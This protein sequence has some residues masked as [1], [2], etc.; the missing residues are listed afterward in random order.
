LDDADLITRLRRSIAE[1]DPVFVDNGDLLGIAVSGGPDSMALL[2]LAHGCFPGRIL[3]ATVDHQLR[4]ES[5]SEAAMVHQWCVSRGI[6]HETLCP[7]TPISGSVQLSARAIRYKLLDAWMDRENIRWLATAH[8]ADDQLETL[9]MRILRGSGLAGLS[10][11]RA[12]RGRVIRPLLSFTRQELRDWAEQN[13]LPFVDDPSNVDRDFD[14]VKVRQMLNGL[15]DFD[16]RRSNR[17]AVIMQQ[18]EDALSWTTKQLARQR[19]R[20]AESSFSFAPDDLH[21][22]YVRRLTEFCLH[23]LSPELQISGP[24]TDRL[25][26]SLQAGKTAMIGN[27]HCVSGDLWQFSYAPPRRTKKTVG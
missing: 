8:H 13:A 27:I 3:A 19:V 21:P 14:R 24:A 18:T 23:Q 1:L 10:G 11:I 25:I 5:A 12:I 22:L 15:Q 6:G 26:S 4:R 20:E 9:V 17:T 2:A 7:E 16:I